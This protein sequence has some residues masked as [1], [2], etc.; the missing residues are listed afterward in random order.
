MRA[1]SRAPPADR[2]DGHIGIAALITT[3]A[4]R[5]GRS[6]TNE[7]RIDVL[8]Q[9]W[10]VISK[11]APR[12]R[13]GQAME[14]VEMETVEQRLRSPQ[15]TAIIRLLTPPF[16]RSSHDRSPGLEVS[17][18]LHPAHENRRDDAPRAARSC[19]HHAGASIVRMPQTEAAVWRNGGE[20]GLDD[21]VISTGGPI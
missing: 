19:S 10:T 8:A 13:A 7:C 14:T 12:E 3:M 4:H 16:D 15:R 1:A 2:E 9:A 18:Y 5:S 20:R 6:R 21:P 17:D 11:A